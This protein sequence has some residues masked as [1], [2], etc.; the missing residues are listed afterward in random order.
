MILENCKKKKFHALKKIFLWTTVSFLVC[1]GWIMEGIY[2]PG[3]S[4]NHITHLLRDLTIC[5]SPFSNALEP[6][7]P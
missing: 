4:F 3:F 1:V 5:S 6:S 2:R 7:G